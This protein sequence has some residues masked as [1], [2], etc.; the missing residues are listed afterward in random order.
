MK[1]TEDIE[2]LTEFE[3]KT[4][5]TICEEIVLIDETLLLFQLT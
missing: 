4:V 1:R 3:F 5:D 2:D